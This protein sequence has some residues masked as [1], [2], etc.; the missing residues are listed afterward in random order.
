MAMPQSMVQDWEILTAEEQLAAEHFISILRQ[1]HK[2][3]QSATAVED[4]AG[5]LRN[6]ATPEKLAGEE[7]A[8]NNAFVQA[9]LRNFEDAE[10]DTD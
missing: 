10:Y 4:L 3:K 2:R 8:L 9:A 6:Y 5:V 1:R 7:E